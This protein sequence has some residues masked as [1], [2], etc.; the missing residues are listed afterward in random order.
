MQVQFSEPSLVDD[1]LPFLRKLQCV[2]AADDAG[3]DARLEL[4]LYLGVWRVMHPD[5]EIRLLP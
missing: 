2:V 3:E 4:G 5:V 1:L